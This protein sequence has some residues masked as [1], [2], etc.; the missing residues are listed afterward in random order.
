[1]LM[2]QNM[3]G[4]SGGGMGMG[5][6]GLGGA[7]EAAGNFWKSEE[8]RVMVR[9]LDFTVDP[10]ASYRY[11]VRIVV[12]N[13]NYQREDVS[14]TAALETKKKQLMG[15]WSKETDVVNMPPDVQPYVVRT[16]PPNP[17]LKSKVLFQV[18]SFNR[19][20]GWTVPH[21]FQGGVGDVIGEPARDDVPSS[22]GSGVRSALIDFS[23]RQ[24]VLDLD[25]GGLQN[26][27]AGLTGPSIDRPAYA[28]MLRHD[29]AMI[30][31][32]QSEDVNNEFRR[33]IAAN[34]KHE[35]EQSS[36]KRESSRGAGYAGMMQMMGG[37]RGGG[38]R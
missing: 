16:L 9:A 22:D 30:V 1:M 21:T 24:I 25:G 23:S 14:P 38:M 10:D 35:K 26:L 8:R 2:M 36:K 7:S 12:A 20:D 18:V 28:A 19:K 32:G 13:P 15:P 5:I 4:G 3:G 37:M 17:A 31:H 11:R 34:Y 33:D 27:P 6:G 29:G